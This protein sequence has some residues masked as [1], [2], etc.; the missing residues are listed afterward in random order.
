MGMMFEVGGGHGGTVNAPRDVEI[1][2]PKLGLSCR[3]VSF[4]TLM[5]ELCSNL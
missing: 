2:S 1:S 5:V 3:K 4:G